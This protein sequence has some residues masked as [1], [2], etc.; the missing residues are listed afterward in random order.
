MAEKLQASPRPFRISVGS[1][2]LPSFHPASQSLLPHLTDPD[3]HH[4]L[5]GRPFTGCNILGAFPSATASSFLPLLFTVLPKPEHLGLP[6][7]SHL[8][9]FLCPSLP[10]ALIQTGQIKISEPLYPR[11]SFLCLSHRH[12]QLQPATLSGG[13]STVELCR[14]AQMQSPPCLLGHN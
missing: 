5:P 1:C 8:R 2:I 14:E 10:W 7:L 11:C 13:I 3:S 4:S 9:T 12:Q 6:L